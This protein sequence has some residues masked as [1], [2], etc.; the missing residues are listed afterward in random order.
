MNHN[1]CVSDEH[2]QSEDR[3]SGLSTQHASA[4]G[5]HAETPNHTPQNP[6]PTGEG[7]DLVERL[8]ERACD[9]RYNDM[10]GARILMNKAAD[11]IETLSSRITTLE[12]DNARLRGEIAFNL[13]AYQATLDMV[14]GENASLTTTLEELR[15]AAYEECAKIAETTFPISNPHWPDN[16][17]AIQ[18]SCGLSIARRIRSALHQPNK[19]ERR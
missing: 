6:P 4:V 14:K 13:T 2:S 10:L 16:S 12:G 5:I 18:N 8:R 1:P 9:Q 7:K 17:E 3:D 19:E 15:R 11:L